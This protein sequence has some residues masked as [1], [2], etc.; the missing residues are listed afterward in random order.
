MLMLGSPPDTD[1][2]EVVRAMRA[3]DGVADVHHLH[4]WQLDERRDALD[5]HVVVTAGDWDRADAIKESV[6]DALRTRFGIERATLETECARH[7]CDGAALFGDDDVDRDSDSHHFGPCRYPQVSR[8]R[9]E[10]ATSGC[11]R[12]TTSPSPSRAR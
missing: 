3:V 8:T 4:L 5:A 1:G 9:R 2:R 7:A 12:Q 10:H 11:R 6:R